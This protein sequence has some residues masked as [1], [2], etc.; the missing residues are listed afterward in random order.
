MNGNPA[1]TTDLDINPTITVLAMVANS[2][3]FAFMEPLT[4]RSDLALTRVKSGRHGLTLAHERGYDVVVSQYP[5]S[6]LGFGEFH[7]RLRS[8]KCA[9][10]QAQL[11]AVTRED[12]RAELLEKLEDDHAHVVSLD[13]DP[14]GFESALNELL[15]GAIRATSRMLMETRIGV[16]SDTG[17]RVFQTVNVSESGLLLQTTKPLPIG[18]RSKFALKLP[19]SDDPIH[20]LAEVVRHT[21]PDTEMVT[22]M[23][24][25]LVRLEGD[26]RA[27]LASF[28]RH[29]IRQSDD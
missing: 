4:E 18:S 15:G 7:S 12:R 20:G 26:G 9:S 27:R 25:R 6:D 17:W 28:V 21:Q 16:G 13:G 23:A 3:V 11:L 2:R 22:G 29:R 14:G 5:L 19:E 24:M 1:S 10:R 8:L